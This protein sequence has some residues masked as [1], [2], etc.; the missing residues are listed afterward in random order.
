LVTDCDFL[1]LDEK[2]R[3]LQ[4]QSLPAKQHPVPEEV[5]KKRNKTLEESAPAPPQKRTTVAPGCTV[6]I[7]NLD[8]STKLPH[9]ET[10]CRKI[11]EAAPS[12]V[13]LCRKSKPLRAQLVFSTSEAAQKFVESVPVDAQIKGVVPHVA[14]CVPQ[15]HRYRRGHGR[16]RAKS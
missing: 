14:V 7:T 1:C 16:A 9:V 5:G 13:R 3:S 6:K 12:S 15:P 4:S 10:F 11:M 8:A 2:E